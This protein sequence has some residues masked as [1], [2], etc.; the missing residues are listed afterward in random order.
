MPEVGTIRTLLVACLLLLG[1]PLAL[2]GQGSAVA[3]GGQ[4]E[5]P[6]GDEDLSAYRVDLDAV[7]LEDFPLGI[8][9]HHM[10]TTRM[11]DDPTR[12][13]VDRDCR[14]HGMGNLYLAGS[15]VFSTGGVATPTFNLTALALRLADHISAGR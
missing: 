9:F 6:R 5:L 1:W 8:G 7:D 4:A 10:C 14:V 2:R 11:A 3:P 15:S 12:G 13:V